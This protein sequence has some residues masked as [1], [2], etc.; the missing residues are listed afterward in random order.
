MG[1]EPDGGKHEKN[2]NNFHD[3]THISNAFYAM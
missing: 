2:P 3:I 1:F